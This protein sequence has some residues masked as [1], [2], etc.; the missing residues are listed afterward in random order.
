[1]AWAPVYASTAELRTFRQIEDT[2]DDT[3]LALAVEAASRS[4][5]RHCNR[6]FGIVASAE[7]RRYQAEYHNRYGRWVIPVDDFQTKT[8]LVIGLDPDE[9]LTFGTSIATT[10]VDYWPPNAAEKGF[11]WTKLVML[12]AATAFP[13]SVLGSVQVTASWGWTA[14]PDTVKQATLL[15]ASRLVSRRLAQFAIG[16]SFEVGDGVLPSTRL[17]GDVR[18]MLGKYRRNW[19]A[20]G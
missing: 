20:V 9:D 13:D 4:I 6:Q 12:P 7:A 19:G 2:D 17:D 15:Q 5:D 1:M 16:G 8:G 3:E 10:E 18:V 11:P 14:V